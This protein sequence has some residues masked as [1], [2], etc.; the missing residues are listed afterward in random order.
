MP[1]TTKDDICESTTGVLSRETGSRDGEPRRKKRQASADG[2]HS[3]Y[4]TICH[5]IQSDVDNVGHQLWAGALLLADYFAV[6]PSIVEGKC[7][8]E[9]GCGCGLTGI[10]LHKTAQHTSLVL[11][12]FKDEILALAARNIERNLYRHVS[13]D[14]NMNGRE[15]DQKMIG[16]GYGDQVNLRILDWSKMGNPR[17]RMSETLPNTW[18]KED[19]V[20]LNSEPVII[21]A[22]DVIYDDALTLHFFQKAAEMMRMGECMYLSLQ[23]R[24]NFE[25]ASMATVAHGYELFRRIIQSKVVFDVCDDAKAF[26][27]ERLSLA[28]PQRIFP[29]VRDEDSLELWKI[30]LHLHRVGGGG[31]EEEEA[32]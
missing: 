10:V 17:D 31:G 30:E 4:L 8:V 21:V 14:D 16:N 27:G 22:A 2:F 23:K 1:S 20:M 6:N 12:D 28:F 26:V 18:R 32:A 5:E 15:R 29:Y 24:F 3:E 11:T 7:V 9:F 25:V 13:Y 19:I